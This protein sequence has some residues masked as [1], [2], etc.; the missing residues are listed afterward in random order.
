MKQ[1]YWYLSLFLLMTYVT[2]AAP[3]DTHIV[4][5]TQQTALVIRVDKDKI[6]TLVHL[7]TKLRNTTEYAAIPG[8]VNGAKTIQVFI[9]PCTRQPGAVTYSNQPSRS[10]M[11]TVIHPSIF[12]TFG[13]KVSP[14]AMVSYKPMYI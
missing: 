8:R 3:D 1:V 12:I 13:M 6:P 7:G 5:E 2:K 11:P 10:L 14:W 4:I 9:I